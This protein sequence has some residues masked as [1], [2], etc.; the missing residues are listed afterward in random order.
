MKD[1][2]EVRISVYLNEKDTEI[3]GHVEDYKGL[4]RW[5]V[6]VSNRLCSEGMTDSF[7]DAFCGV[8]ESI[9]HALEEEFSVN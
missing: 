7:D 3:H 4:W 8:A 6:E 5:R 2:I 1:K 9:Q